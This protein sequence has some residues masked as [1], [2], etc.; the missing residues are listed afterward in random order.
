M[1]VTNFL[2]LGGLGATVPHPRK[3]KEKKT[4]ILKDSEIK[5]QTDNKQKE[6]QKEK[7]FPGGWRV[8]VVLVVVGEK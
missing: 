3:W 6:R 7:K 4:D 1:S 2:S 5:K 8:V